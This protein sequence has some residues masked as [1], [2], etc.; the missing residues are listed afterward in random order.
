MK[1]KLRMG[2]MAV[3][4][5]VIAMVAYAQ[6]AQILTER[7]IKREAVQQQQDKMAVNSV[8][9]ESLLKTE[10]ISSSISYAEFFDKAAERN[11]SIDSAITAAQATKL[12]PDS[13]VALLEYGQ[14]LEETL[15][16]Q[17]MYTR[18]RLAVSNAADNFKRAVADFA[19]SPYNEYSYPWEK[20]RTDDAKA[21]AE[22]AVKEAEKAQ[23][24][25]KNSLI[26]LRKVTKKTSSTLSG[27]RLVSD[28]VIAKTITSL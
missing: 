25:F 2:A 11:K 15:R 6:I 14:A 28:E 24:D 5:I 13:K 16:S 26:E 8:G 9:A 21:E 19:S 7:R 18:K 12:D 27:Y 3:A 20:K 10:Y 4:A 1:S 17:S 23:S 22:N